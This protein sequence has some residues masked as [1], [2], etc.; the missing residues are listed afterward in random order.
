MTDTPRRPTRQFPPTAG[1]ANCPTPFDQ[2]AATIS[3]Y[4]AMALYVLGV[5]STVSP[6]L[7]RCFVVLNCATFTLG[8]VGIIGGIARRA[9]ATIW[10][11]VVGAL[12][13]GLPLAFLVLLNRRN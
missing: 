12:L 2:R 13:S 7:F 8:V 9:T 11:A 10:T 3:C 6:L 4:A 1:R 5:F